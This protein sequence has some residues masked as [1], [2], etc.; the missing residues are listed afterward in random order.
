MN[1]NFS[2]KK[3]LLQTKIVKREDISD[4]M[5]KIWVTKP[6]EYS[7]KP[8]QYCTLGVNGIERAY[9]IASSPDE[10]L[11]ELFVELVEK[12]EGGVLTPIIWDMKEGDIFTIRPKAKGIFQIKDQT[13]NNY[14]LI[15]TVT[16]VVPYVSFA[17]TYLQN[18]QD[19]MKFHILQGSSYVDEF[20]YFDELQKLS[21]VN[22]QNLNYV[23]TISR[24]NEK[25]NLSWEGSV[26]R[27]NLIVDQY[28]ES[29]NLS[30]EN[31][32]VFACGNPDMII[33]IQNNLEHK[34]GFTVIEERFWK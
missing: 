15:S 29:N 19:N 1:T 3:K 26:G 10:N 16:G 5:I 21:V 17:R 22:N 18:N 14:L 33:D 12:D 27:V 24:P 6:P 9:S 23:P 32:I 28:I 7:F 34:K 30:P 8:G 2:S 13:L 25:R 4:L 31:T 20:G 11:I